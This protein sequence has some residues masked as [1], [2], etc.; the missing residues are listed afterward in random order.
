MLEHLS[1]LIEEGLG[2]VA[3]FKMFEKDYDF[4]ARK[5]ILEYSHLES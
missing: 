5:Q 1:E 2:R 3:V 4:M